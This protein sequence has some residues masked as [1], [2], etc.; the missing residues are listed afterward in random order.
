MAD[1]GSQ[2]SKAFEVRHPFFRPAWRR[3][4]LTG[5]CLVWAIIEFRNGSNMWGLMFGAA[6]VHLFVQFFV[7]FDPADYEKRKDK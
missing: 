2:I 5:F 6:G 1:K 7:R 3:V 4:L